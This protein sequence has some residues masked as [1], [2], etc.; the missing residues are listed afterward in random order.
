[1]LRLFAAAAVLLLAA[2]A[3][4]RRCTQALCPSY[5]NGAY[6]VHGWNGSVTVD[7][8]VP[9]VPIVSDATVDVLSGQ[10]EFG[11]D[12]AIVAGT[13]GASFRFQVSSGAIAVPSVTVASGN[14]YVALSSSS[15]PSLIEPGKTFFLPVAEQ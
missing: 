10:I 13:A 15:E 7:P 3:A 12:H 11:N 2:C 9:A 1:M 4:P 5:V 14:V 8:G 6:R